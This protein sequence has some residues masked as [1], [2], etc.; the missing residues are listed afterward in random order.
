MS[1][2]AQALGILAAAALRREPATL[3]DQERVALA[4]AAG[5]PFEIDVDQAGKTTLR[6]TRPVSFTRGADGKITVVQGA[7]R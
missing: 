3:T 7:Q 6:I 2:A 5:V 1:R 4:I